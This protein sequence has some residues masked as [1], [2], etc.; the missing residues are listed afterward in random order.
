MGMNEDDER[1]LRSNAVLMDR[2]LIQDVIGV[3]GMGSVYSARDLHFPKV[4]KLVA[5][6]EMINQAPD[7]LV[8]ATIVQN[9]EREANIL[10]T[11]NHPSIPKIF[12]FFTY[13]DRSYLVEEYV[14]GRDLEAILKARNDFIPEDQVIGW[15]IEL[16]DVLDF[17]HNHK[18]EP[19]IFRDMKPSNIMI[20]A[21]NR[22]VLVDFGIAKVF[23]TNQKGTM[24]GTEGYS[25]PE[26]YRG[27]ATPLADIY[28]LGATLHH[29]LTMRDPRLEPPFTFNERPIK[30]YNPNVSLE[31]ETVVN[32]A[33]NYNPQ[34]RF[35]DAAAMKEALMGVARKTGALARLAASTGTLPRAEGVK[36][37]WTFECEDEIRNAP[38]YDNGIIYIGAYDNNLYAINAANGEF[39]W[40]Y[41]TDGGKP[42]KPA[43]YDNTLYLGSEYTRLHAVSARS[44]KVMW[45]Y[46]TD[47]PVRSSPRIAEGHAFFGSDDG[48]LHV[49]NLNTNRLAWRSEAGA[50]VRSSP[51]ISNEFIYYGCESGDLTCC[52][53]RG[54]IK[55]RFQAKR[56]I[57]ASPLVDHNMVFVTSADG[58]CYA[59]DAKSGWVIWRFRMDKGSISSPVKMDNNLYFGSADGNLYCLDSA[60]GREIWRFR[61]DHQIASTPAIYKD[62]VYIGSVDGNLYAVDISNGRQRWKFKT[63]KAII[64]SPL[65]FNDIVYVGSTDYIVYALLA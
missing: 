19:I 18:P 42:T 14:S 4:V 28:A 65:V 10:V 41:A 7:P 60:N 3:G 1:Q 21:H 29:L 2:Y 55:W 34:D 9:F 62:A 11:L 48:Y 46:F 50:P 35:K 32:T 63:G 45:T 57:T 22:V 43:V 61:T 17:L 16:C 58:F 44:G 30:R 39:V 13:K 52:D 47:G 40:K 8:R 51:F 33:L 37:L 36:P 23:T 25:P 24:I 54:T 6:K 38:T 31:L 56:G 64:G 20:N 5:V 26:Q 12:D 59:L 27:E 53:F 15:A 49:V